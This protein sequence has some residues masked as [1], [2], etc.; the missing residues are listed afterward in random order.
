VKTT[1]AQRPMR[2]SGTRLLG[3]GK[4]LN[5]VG[6][7]PIQP[8]GNLQ[9]R[10]VCRLRPGGWFAALQDG[11]FGRGQVHCHLENDLSNVPSCGGNRGFSKQQ[12]L[13]REAR[14]LIRLH[15]C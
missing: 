10:F 5:Q 2:P 4:N 9:R 6:V 3:S 14:L 7:T 12:R 15:G 13:F 8:D 1:S 11:L